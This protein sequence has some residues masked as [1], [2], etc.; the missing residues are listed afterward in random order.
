MYVCSDSFFSQIWISL[1]LKVPFEPSTSSKQPI[2][3][4]TSV[5]TGPDCYRCQHPRLS[6]PLEGVSALISSLR[7]NSSLRLLDVS[8]NWIGPRALR[9][10]LKGMATREG[11]RH[12]ACV[13][14]AEVRG[15]GGLR[16]S[17]PSPPFYH[18]PFRK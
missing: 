4:V 16:P 3:L 10:C 11:K 5:T 14:R 17:P 1:W 8:L 2:N 9:A 7:Y 12:P 15:W 18:H 6:P 13:V